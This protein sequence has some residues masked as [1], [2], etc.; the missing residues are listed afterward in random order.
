MAQ[1]HTENYAA[2]IWPFPIEGGT[3]GGGRAGKFN[4]LNRRILPL[5]ANSDGTRNY[6]SY[7]P[8]ESRAP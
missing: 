1:I 8:S 4:F 7:P 6:C 3:K 5:F 2:P